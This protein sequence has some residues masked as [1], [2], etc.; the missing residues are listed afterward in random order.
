MNRV[1]PPEDLAAT[2][3]ELAARMVER[4]PGALAAIK[5]SLHRSYELS[6]AEALEEEAQAQAARTA[7]PAFLAAMEAY[8]W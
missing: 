2:A 4:L 8:R 3:N 1:V 5:R 7:D 6:L